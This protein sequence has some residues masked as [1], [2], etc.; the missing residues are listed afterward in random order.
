MK[1]RSEII[2]EILD[3]IYGSR[4]QAIFFDNDDV[5]YIPYWYDEMTDSFMTE[6]VLVPIAHNTEDINFDVIYD[7]IDELEG[8]LMEYFK[9]KYDIELLSCETDD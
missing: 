1:T 2:Q 4:I 3:K 8:K 9:N 7:Y 5:P 6:Y